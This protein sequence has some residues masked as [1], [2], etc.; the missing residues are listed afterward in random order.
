MT[1]NA[2]LTELLHAADVEDLDV[3]TDYLTDKGDGRLMLDGDV[4]K[5]L[6]RCKRNGAYDPSDR[7]LIAKEIRAFGG[8]TLVNLFR[9]GGVEHPELTRDV[10]DHMKVPYAKSASV[11][12]VELAILQK[13]FTDA[14][15]RMSPDERKKTLEELNIGDLAGAGPGAVAAALAAGRFAGFAAYKMAL[16]VANAI[17]KAI[18]G[19]GLPLVVNAALTRT[20]GVM[21]GPVGWVLTG[22]WT[23]ADLASPAYRVTVPCVV[24]IAYMR[25]KALAA[26]TTR[27]CP[28]CHAINTAGAKFCAECGN[29]LK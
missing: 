23:L 15:D 8:N 13:L 4:T 10:A 3:L 27:T 5:R 9:G 29:A 20:M 6:V 24:Q 1:A 21:L 18:L 28:A 19:R 14:L 16:I 11:V 22:V 12:T 7:S 25:Q 2:S 17:A 26:S